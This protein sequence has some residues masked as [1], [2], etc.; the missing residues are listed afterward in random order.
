V[1]PMMGSSHSG[2]PPS[3]KL[4]SSSCTCPQR[5]VGGHRTIASGAAVL[6]AGHLTFVAETALRRR[7][8]FATE[9]S[10]AKPGTTLA[11]PCGQAGVNGRPLLGT[12]GPD[13][14]G[15]SGPSRHSGLC[16]VSSE[17]GPS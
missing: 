7:A 14:S 1:R 6:F 8:E 10:C 16:Y 11:R 17:G 12:A 3:A 13:V 5:P 9:P 2:Q 15:E 4:A